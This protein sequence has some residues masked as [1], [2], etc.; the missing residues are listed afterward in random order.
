MKWFKKKNEEAVEEEEYREPE[1]DYHEDITATEY[2][3]TIYDLTNQTKKQFQRLM[4]L[5]SDSTQSLDQLLSVNRETTDSI[6]EAAD[7]SKGLE[8]SNSE[9]EEKISAVAGEMKTSKDAIEGSRDHFSAM[10]DIVKDLDSFIGNITGEMTTLRTE[11]DNISTKAQ[12]I[13]DIAEST[14]ILALNASIEA[15][16]AGEAGKGFA[17]VANETSNLAQSTKGF[18]R[19]ILS[20]MNELRNVVMKLQKQVEAVTKV[21]ERTN[22]TVGEVTDGF[23]TI[24]TSDENVSVHLDDVLRLQKEN[25]EYIRKM[26]DT[27]DDVVIKSEE[28]SDRIQ[29]LVDSVNDRSTSYKDI[30]N[31]LEQMNLLADKAKG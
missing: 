28:N 15:N 31:D 2:Y 22:S 13:D 27:M 7:A 1:V 6:H 26:S 20:S 17:V 14:T 18:S 8:Q 4:N 10:N 29:T 30:A 16:R 3:S 5:E 24:R 21:I 25:M 11:F 19:D 12:S 23:E 9:L